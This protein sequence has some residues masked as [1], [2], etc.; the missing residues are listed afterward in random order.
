MLCILRFVVFK[1]NLRNWL[2]ISLV[3][4]W[5][6]IVKHIFKY[7][8]IWKCR[9]KVCQSIVLCFSTAG[10]Y[11]RMD[12]IDFMAW[13]YLKLF[14]QNKYFIPL[15]GAFSGFVASAEFFGASGMTV[16]RPVEYF[17]DLLYHGHYNKVF[18]IKF[19]LSL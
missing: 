10:P 5:A 6:E 7:L 1:F 15:Y 16:H 11:N 14:F 19:P 4:K 18:Y 8:A 2:K 17:Y 9:R 12:S 3:E 13:L